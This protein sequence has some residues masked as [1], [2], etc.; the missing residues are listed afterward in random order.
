MLGS[1]DRLARVAAGPARGLDLEMVAAPRL[2]ADELPAAGDADALLGPLVGLHLR[3]DWPH[4]PTG[5]ASA[6]GFG[7]ATGLAAAGSA[8]CAFRLG[9]GLRLRGGLRAAVFGSAAGSGFGGGLRLRR[10]S[11]FAPAGFAALHRLLGR[12]ASPRGCVPLRG[13]RC[14]CRGRR[15]L[16]R[17]RCVLRSRSPERPRAPR[18][19]A[20]AQVAVL[21]DPRL[22]DRGE[23]HE[24]RFAF[25]HRR[26]VDGAVVLDRVAEPGE[27]RPTDLR[28]GQLPSAEADGHLDPV[29]ILEELDRAVDLRREVA[30]ADL[31]RQADLLEL[32]RALLP[33][34]FLLAL[35]QLVL[36]LPEVEKSDH[37]R[38]RRRRDLDEIEPTLL[39]HGERLWCRHDA[40]LLALII[41]DPHLWDTDHLVH[42]QV[43][44][45]GYVPLFRGG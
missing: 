31:R 42:A 18:P 39:R 40:E 7:S 6:T 43:S 24:H 35:R 19:R 14:G 23:R 36:V 15:G 3:H 1:H 2:D 17:H 45:D 11:G 10:G 32:D 38:G 27:Q 21:V 26:P 28:V 20:A 41:D 30:H 13:R 12:R 34:G 33:L 4:S 16:R 37:R 25:E 9:G 22:V 8:G 29:A 5:A 44:A